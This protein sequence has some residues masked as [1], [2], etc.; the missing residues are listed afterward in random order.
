MADQP[1]ETPPEL[2]ELFSGPPRK[3]TPAEIKEQRISFAIGTMGDTSL[4]RE[5]L[6]AMDAESY[7]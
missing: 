1:R 7:G 5:E 2:V 3:L 6:E 4:T